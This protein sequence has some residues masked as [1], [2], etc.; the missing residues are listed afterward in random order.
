MELDYVKLKAIKPVI[1][2]YIKQSQSLLKISVVPDEKEVHDIR[3]LMKKSRAAL[4]L[5]GPQLDT[6]SYNRDFLAFR[7]VGRIMCSWR[8]TSVHRKTLKELRKENPDIF[9]RLQDNE[10]LDALC[11]KTELIQEMSEETKALLELINDL[12]KKTGYRLRFQTMNKIDPQLLIKELDL[13]YNTVT[14]I[15]LGCRY[16]PKP[17]K[18]H[19]FRKRAKDFLYQL[20]FFRPLNP[21]IIK[22]LEKRL[23]LMTRNLG[24]F[25]DLTQ[26]VRELNYIYPDNTN[27]PALNELMIRIREKQDG[28]L[29]KVWP[30]AYKVF[31][32]GQKLVNI[33]GFKLLVI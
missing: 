25:N 32:P 16:N 31:C 8:E 2:G 13:T 3:V 1:A 33:L 10:K 20:S 27:P 30:S 22:A 24:K 15:Y 28:Y 14:D 9:L 5:A 19:E 23:D 18:L 4:K 12:L 7:E 26:L 17:D 29:A 11:R 21:S 6:G